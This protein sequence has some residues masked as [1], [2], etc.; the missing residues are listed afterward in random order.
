VALSRQ[1]V[2]ALTTF[3]AAVC[4]IFGFFGFAVAVPWTTAVMPVTEALQ[5]CPGAIDP[6]WPAVFCNHSQPSEW[7]YGLIED[8][9]IRFARA[10]LQM[11]VRVGCFPRA[12]EAPETLSLMPSFRGALRVPPQQLAAVVWVAQT[13]DA[14]AVPEL[15]EASGAHPRRIGTEPIPSS[16][17]SGVARLVRCPC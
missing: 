1:D 7:T 8:H 12:R 10:W 6:S 4:L 15:V 11:I 5:R 3:G 16:D 2:G 9:P 14:D 17:G 13:P